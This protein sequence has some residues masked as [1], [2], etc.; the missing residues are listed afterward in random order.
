[1]DNDVQAFGEKLG[2]CVL[3]RKWDGVREMLAPWLQQKF[4]A[5]QVQAFFED[6]YKSTLAF[7]KIDQL[8]YPEDPEPAID[9]NTHTNATSL[10]DTKGGAVRDR[11]LAP[12]V[13]DDIVRYWMSLTLNCSEEQQSELDLDNL[14]EF[15][16]LVVEWKGQLCV[17]YLEPEG[18]V[19]RN[20]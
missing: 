11:E 9:G 14:G 2:K 13:T 12:E 6:E 15:W 18:W 10:R 20:S 5:A 4:S 3:A 1:M 17:G 16:V 8:H 19:Y 7:S